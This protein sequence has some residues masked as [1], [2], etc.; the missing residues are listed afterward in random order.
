VDNGPTVSRARK[1]TGGCVRLIGSARMARREIGFASE[2][3]WF[4][5]RARASPRV[6]AA[7]RTCPSGPSRGPRRSIRRD[8]TRLRLNRRASLDVCVGRPSE[9]MDDQPAIGSPCTGAGRRLGLR[10]ARSRSQDIGAGARGAD[11]SRRA[12]G[13][14]VPRTAASASQFMS[15]VSRTF[16]IRSRGTQGF[17]R[18]GTL[19]PSSSRTAACLA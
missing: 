11:S 4:E 13:R 3:D 2:D 16:R 10:R 7:Y 9:V 8:F 1:R 18:N 5:Y 14:R 12:R 6:L 17:A 15:R 19:R